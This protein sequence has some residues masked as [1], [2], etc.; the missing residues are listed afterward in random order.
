MKDLQKLNEFVSLE[1]QEQAVRLQ[2]NLG[3][4]NFQE[5]IKK[6]FE[7]VSKSFNDVSEGV[8][9]TI[10][11]SSNSNN[12]ALEN[13]NNKL[14]EIKIDRGILA[15]YLMS[16]LSK[17]SNP[18]KKSQF[19]ILKEHNSNRVND[20]LIKNTIPI[21]LHGNM[22]IFRD[23]VNEIELKRDLLKMIAKK[24]NNV[25]LASLSD[26]ELMYDFSREM[27]FDVKA[28]VENPLEIVLL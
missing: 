19:T 4:Q 2:E 13:L 26:K 17:I 24:N 9:K 21:T 7:S 10:T 25:D 12:K 6:V 27:N 3:K 22:L 1:N 20:S 11:E 16:P 5:D 18:E 14:L 28:L 23:T 15:T 8:T